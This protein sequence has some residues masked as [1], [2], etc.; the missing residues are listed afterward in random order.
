PRVSRN[1]HEGMGARFAALVSDYGAGTGIFKQK[2]LFG[3]VMFV[4]RNRLV[5][6]QGLGKHKEVFRL[7]ELAIDLNR[8]RNASE[9]ARAVYQRVSVAFLQNQGDGRLKSWT[10]RNALLSV[11]VLLTYR[12]AGQDRRGNRR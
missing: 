11:L 9:R 12:N 8:E 6:C 4:K 1:E 2:N 7:T 10:V 3:V 5:R